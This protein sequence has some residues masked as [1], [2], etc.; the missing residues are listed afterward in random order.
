M[1]PMLADW[2]REVL[3][4]LT[5]LRL[6]SFLSFR[7]IMAALTSMAFMFIVARR[8]IDY[9]HRRHMV[10]LV[11]ETGLGTAQDK[12]GTPT[13]GGAMIIVGVLLS[14]AL[15]GRLDSGFI[16][17]T[18]WAMIW[19]GGLGMMDDLAKMRRRSGDKGMSEGMKFAIQG[20]FAVLFAWLFLSSASPLP[21]ELLHRFYVPF[22]KKPVADL[23]W[24]I[25][26]CFIIF[27]VLFVSNSVN[28][29]D[30][31]DGLAI[32][33]SNF[34][35][36]VLGVFAYIMG[37]K[38]QAGYLQYPYLPG[39]GELLVM[40]SAFVGAGL[41]FLW[42]NAYPAQVFMGDTGSLGIGGT[43]AVMCVLLKQ[44]LLFPILGGVFLVEGFSSQLQD[45]I[46]VRWLGRRLFYRAP[47]HH[48][49]QYRGLA[50]TKVVI[51]L[52]I[53]AGI[54]ALISLA[55]LKIR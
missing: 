9:L 39:A 1:I 18:M 20:G 47:F 4:E 36:G 54:L 21:Q 48:D 38:I 16:L 32:M 23:G 46:G 55:S 11:R 7:S 28:I 53:I 13:M 22:Y 5:F 33:P 42:Y 12:K 41:G 24:L 29:T 45:K 17:T 6:A 35:I 44:E 27:F 14:T 37:N 40:A 50:E 31:L 49:L 2:L 25:Y 8:F 52:W 34:V 43:I 19:F 15:W 3:P 26:F 51:R 30:G 10:D